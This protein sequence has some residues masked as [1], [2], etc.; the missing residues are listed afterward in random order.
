MKQM[1]SVSS[2]LNKFLCIHTIAS[3]ATASATA[4]AAASAAHNCR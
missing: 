1:I 3:A 2:Y 4:S